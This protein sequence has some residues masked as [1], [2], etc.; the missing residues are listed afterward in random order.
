MITHTSFLF[1]YLLWLSGSKIAIDTGF[2]TSTHGAIGARPI[3]S[4]TAMGL[5]SLG[6]TVRFIEVE[7]RSIDL[8][9]PQGRS[10]GNKTYQ[11][12]EIN[13]TIVDCCC[14]CCDVPSDALPTDHTRHYCSRQSGVSHSSLSQS[15]IG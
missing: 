10:F 9:A 12:N 6:L 1:V 14:R 13:L 5:L 11:A 7:T 3:R 4:L 2:H 15:Q 8:R